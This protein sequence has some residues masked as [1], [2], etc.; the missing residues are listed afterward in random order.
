M[1]N[2]DH[3]VWL[4]TG[5]SRGL[6]LEIAKAA[7]DA[8]DALVATA[9]DPK[10]LESALPAGERTHHVALDVTD[11]GQAE[12]AVAEAKARFG[13]IDVLVNNAGYGQLGPFEEISDEA[14]VA[15]FD[16]NV[17]GVARVTRAVLPTMRERR[18]GRIFNISSIGGALGFDA[19]GAYCATKFAVEGLSETL[20][21]ELAP[22]GIGVTI[23]E[24]GFFRTDFLDPRSVRFSDATVADYG[25]YSRATRG[26]YSGNNHRQPGDPA[27][28]GAA[29]VALSRR[30]EVPM[31]FVAGTDAIGYMR[32]AHTKRL[33]ELEKYA[34]LS[35]STDLAA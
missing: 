35:G 7:L 10:T 24:P 20:A 28:L 5:T 23:V 16:T 33:A 19:A 11:A 31:R 30:E 2:D 22:F 25:D 6:G 18:S 32:T 4:I 8:G 29:L 12:A 34:G 13:R 21:L 15:Q 26:S 9:R 1:T 3:K 17:H 14:F 27:K